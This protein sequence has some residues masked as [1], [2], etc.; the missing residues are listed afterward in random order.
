MQRRRRHSA[1]S[2]HSFSLRK[3]IAFSSILVGGFFLLVE[4]VLRFVIG[5]ESEAVSRSLSFHVPE[6][7]SAGYDV[8]PD[9]YWK[10]KPGFAGQVSENHEWEVRTNAH[11]MR[12]PET[13]KE[14]PPGTVRVIVMGDSSAFGWGVAEPE[15]FSRRLESRLREH[16]PGKKYE[17]LNAGVPGYSSYQGLLYLRRDLVHF[18]PDVVLTYFG[19]NDLT[20][21]MYYMDKEQR[22]FHTLP[23]PSALSFIRNLRLWHLMVDLVEKTRR[24]DRFTAYF[25]SRDLLRVTPEDYR[26][27][28][29]AMRAVADERGFRVFFITPVWKSPEGVFFDRPFWFQEPL[30]LTD[31]LSPV[32]DMYRVIKGHEARANLIYMD[33]AHP[34]TEGHA[35]FAEE[36]VRALVEAGI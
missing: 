24:R 20:G 36:I 23:R 15:T 10:L 12:G 26:A 16:A 22:G 1:H 31:G 4:A 9:R 27:N 25:T 2:S 33:V 5:Y 35:L 13:T 18:Q 30:R 14:K 17:V 3:S 6:I 32:I 29:R 8:D 19:L 28:L 11:G 34:N 21:A 7:R